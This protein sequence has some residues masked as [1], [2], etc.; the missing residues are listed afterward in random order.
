MYSQGLG[1]AGRGIL[2]LNGSAQTVEA[3]PKDAAAPIVQTP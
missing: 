2:S 3:G 1:K